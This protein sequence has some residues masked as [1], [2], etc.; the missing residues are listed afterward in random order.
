MFIHRG[1]SFGSTGSSS[2]STGRKSRVPDIIIREGDPTHYSPLPCIQVTQIKTSVVQKVV[3]QDDLDDGEY[4][5]LGASSSNR[6][7]RRPSGEMQRPRSPSSPAALKAPG[8]NSRRV[9]LIP[10]EALEQAH[11]SLALSALAQGRDPPSSA[12]FSHHKATSEISEPREKPRVEKSK[13]TDDGAGGGDGGDGGTTAN[14]SPMRMKSNQRWLKLRTTVQLSGALSSSM[15]RAKPPLKR[16]DSFIKRFSTRQI[17]ELQDTVDQTDE[18]DISKNSTG[19]PKIRKKKKKKRTPRTVINPYGNV[20]F[21]WL[22]V[23]TICVLYNLWTTIVRQA[24]PELQRQPQPMWYLLDGMTDMVFV[25]DILVQFRTGYLEQG[26]IVRDFK[27]LARHYTHSRSFL[28]DLASLFPLDFLQ[29]VI[30]S[31]PIIRFPRF[32]KV[33]RVYNYY[34]MVESRTLYPNMWRVV[35]LVHILLLLAHW[36]GCF[37]Y[38][39][40]EAEQFRG[41]W[42][43]PRY[44]SEDFKTLSRKYLGSVYWSTLTLTTIGDLPTPETNRHGNQSYEDMPHYPVGVDDPPTHPPFAAHPGDQVTEFPV[45]PCHPR[46]PDPGGGGGGGF[47]KGGDGDREPTPSPAPH[48][49]LPPP[50]PPPPLA[51]PWP[52]PISLDY[53]ES[54][55]HDGDQ[56]VSPALRDP[57][58][59]SPSISSSGPSKSESGGDGEAEVV[60]APATDSEADDDNWP[61][62]LPRRGLKSRL[63]RIKTNAGYIFTIVSYLIGVFIFATIVGQVGN[64][65]TNR[66]ANRLEFER[67]LDGAKLYMRHHKV[68]RAMQRRVQRWYDYSWSRGRI[69]GGGDINMALGLLPDKLKTELA[70]H[71]NLATLKKVSIFKEC[72]PEFLHDLVLKMKAYIFTPGDLICRKGEV[73]REMFIIADGI[74]EVISETGKVLTTMKAGD[75]FGEIG[76]LN[77]DGLNKRT[78]DVRSVGYSELFSLSREDVL[79]AMKDYPEAQE[80][81]QSLGRKRLMEARHQTS[82]SGSSGSSKRGTP[83]P[84]KDGGPDDKNAKRI[85]SRIRSDVSAIRNAFR[86]SKGTT[87]YMETLEQDNFPGRKTDNET[88]ELEPLTGDHRSSTEDDGPAV[89]RIL[90]HPSLKK[91]GSKVIKR[92]S[93]RKISGRSGSDSS[94][95]GARGVLKRMARVTS[96][97]TNQVV[98]PGRTSSNEEQ[99][100]LGA[101]LPLL[102]RLKLLKEKEDKE[103]RERQRIKEEEAKQQEPAPVEEEPEV[104]GA[105]LPLFARLRLLKAK[106]EKERMERE[107]KEQGEKEKGKEEEK[108]KAEEPPKKLVSPVKDQPA[109]PPEAQEGPAK[110]VP[111]QPAEV[112]PKIGAGLMKNKLRAAVLS[113]AAPPPPQAAPAAAAAAVVAGETASKAEPTTSAASSSSTTLTTTSQTTEAPAAGGLAGILAKKAKA[114]AEA[115]SQVKSPIN[116]LNKGLDTKPTSEGAVDKVGNNNS[117]AAKDIHANSNSVQGGD[118]LEKAFGKLLSKKLNTAPKEKPI[119]PVIEKPATEVLKLQFTTTKDKINRSDSFKRAMDEGLIRS[120]DES[121]LN[122]K[123]SEE[124][125]KVVERSKESESEEGKQSSE[126]KKGGESQSENEV[127]PVSDSKQIVSKQETEEGRRKSI[128]KTSK[129][130]SE[131]GLLRRGSSEKKDSSP[132]EARRQ[133]SINV[134]TIQHKKIDSLKIASHL[135]CFTSSKSNSHFSSSQNQVP[136]EDVSPPLSSPESTETPERKTLKSILKRMSRED[137]KG[138]LLPPDGA[139][140]RKLMKA[141]TVE[142]FVARRSKFS[143]SVSFQRKTLSS[144]P[145]P[146]LLDELKN[147]SSSS[148]SQSQVE[149]SSVPVIPT[150]VQPPTSLKG[151]PNDSCNTTDGV[152]KLMVKLGSIG[153]DGTADPQTQDLVLGVRKILRDKMDDVEVAWVARVKELQQQLADRDATIR[154]LTHTISRLQAG[155]MSDGI[156]SESSPENGGSARPPA[157]IR[158]PSEASISGSDD[159]EPLF[160]RC[161]SIESIIHQ[162]PDGSPERMHAPLAARRSWPRQSSLDQRSIHPNRFARSLETTHDPNHIILDI[163]SSTDEDLCSFSSDEDHIL[164]GELSQNYDNE[165]DE[166]I[167]DDDQISEDIFLVSGVDGEDNGDDDDDDGDDDDE[168]EDEIDDDDAE[169][170]ESGETELNSQDWEVQLLARQLAEE[171]RG[172]AR[173]VD[174]DI[175]EGRLESALAELHEALATDKL[176]NL[177][178]G[179]LVRLEKAVRTE[180][181][182]LRRYARL[183]S[184]DERPVLEDQ[185]TS[186]YRSRSQLLLN[187]SS[188]L[189]RAGPTQRRLSSLLVQL[190]KMT[191]AEQFLLDRLVYTSARKRKLSR[192]RSL[193]EDRLRSQRSNQLLA[194]RRSMSMCSPPPGS[195]PPTPLRDT[196]SE[197]AEL[198][199]DPSSEGE[200][201]PPTVSV[202]LSS[203]QRSVAAISGRGRTAGNNQGS[204]KEGAP[205]L[206]SPR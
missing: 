185:F 38:M 134:P 22:C 142:G 133:P 162:S 206:Q 42:T 91:T 37:Y 103:E 24:F 65:I 60:E 96:D 164:F 104:I 92:V 43:Y 28:L 177:T 48:T 147:S 12:L 90:K 122:I 105:G 195:T 188:E 14:S 120:T 155:A 86:R 54:S 191:P 82:K 93:F 51:P 64:V 67:L 136:S 193:C 204:Q 108:G 197:T 140:L 4:D 172:V 56:G 125:K 21:Y 179:D 137:S 131:E 112:K 97:E 173:Q 81:L 10:G 35:N 184:L 158:S 3:D 1:E 27:K 178:E 84:N 71:V 175:A 143:K 26:L 25:V 34:Y 146:A 132:V 161:N 113:K 159:D 13:T 36:F 73:A 169:P 31:N 168:N 182:K 29:F 80:I 194:T 199:R 85:V 102:Q 47:V 171:Q 116:D 79:T 20:Y 49:P 62:A 128:D 98:S 174:R 74:L 66:N 40:S 87:R 55:P 89:K 186:L 153:L 111:A 50:P 119:S 88:M 39:L 69:Q 33:Y 83:S 114:D 183:Y 70:L 145:P 124:V 94:G 202:M 121:D 15:N 189:C 196:A 163:G 205:L 123:P 110:E 75:F 53:D 156:C 135:P 127:S 115:K 19:S 72:Q 5:Y 58:R 144:P 139:D 109:K 76:I 44:Q 138:N 152:S 59:L 52:K 192:Q 2:G 63:L 9:S 18:E 41:D 106:E 61:R 129:P 46:C 117:L 167:G 201:A 150:I 165:F 11:A 166:E 154:H 100:V 45:S 101:G 181:E 23:L 148:S 68:P 170:G 141:P 6:A 126:D 176:G 95:G 30:G 107:E 180:R 99:G 118:A 7:N 17:A 77:L 190:T 130:E 32:I 149:S 198:P 8:R 200:S 160:M 157:I 78:A 203:L 151:K 187:R 57:F 16:E